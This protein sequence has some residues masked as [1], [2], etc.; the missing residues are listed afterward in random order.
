MHVYGVM[1]PYITF[2][3]CF[4]GAVTLCSYS[5][6]DSQLGK[7]YPLVLK[8]S[9]SVMKKCSSFQP[10]SPEELLGKQVLLLKGEGFVL[11]R[12]EQ[13]RDS[14]TKR[15]S[16]EPRTTSINIHSTTKMNMIV[17]PCTKR[18]TQ[19]D[20]VQEVVHCQPARMVRKHATD[21]QKTSKQINNSNWTKDGFS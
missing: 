20:R 10:N 17:I 8:R 6:T 4:N 5:F 11:C 14:C 15:V 9:R 1:F 3:E 19:Q 7:H 21:K 18:K 2:T 12:S 13:P 16:K